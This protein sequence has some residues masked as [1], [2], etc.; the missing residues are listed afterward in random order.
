MSSAPKIDRSPLYTLAVAIIGEGNRIRTAMFSDYSEMVSTLVGMVLRNERFVW[1]AAC[2]GKVFDQDD[3]DQTNHTV[4]LWVENIL[5]P[6]SRE[7]DEFPTEIP[8]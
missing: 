6:P 4:A 8:F 5:N 3:L 2:L 1:S 7:I